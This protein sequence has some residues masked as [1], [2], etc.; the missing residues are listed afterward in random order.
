MKLWIAVVCMAVFTQFIAT[1]DA[2]ACDVP[3]AHMYLPHDQAID[4][5][6]WIVLAEAVQRSETNGR[7]SYQM[8]AIEH[9]K[10][11]G[12]ETFTIMN[13]NEL[14]RAFRHSEEPSSANYFAHQTSD[15]WDDAK[16]YSNWPDCR[17]HPV[18]GFSGPRYLIFGP[19]D[20][21]IGFENVTENDAWLNYVRQRVAGG[22]PTKPFPK[23]A[24]DYFNDAKAIVRVTA[25][26]KHNT[27]VWKETVIKGDK[28][29]YITTLF[30]SPAAEL[31]SYLN[32]ACANQPFL[33]HYKTFDF[34]YVLEDE[35]KIE[36]NIS[37]Y[38]WCLGD[39]H[40]Q[41]GYV[42]SYGLYPT[43]GFQR[44]EIQKERI[45]L[46]HTESFMYS[47]ERKETYFPK[48][49][50]EDEITLEQLKRLLNK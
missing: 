34:L 10:G 49:T 2:L 36:D 6:E 12:P 47:K 41:D 18:F 29:S 35:P 14:Q 50:I 3:P 15:F 21:A 13:R 38:L 11:S 27:A 33:P 30:I 37:R 26:W 1:Q 43:T 46:E 23:T 45:N 5:A 4:D 44:F 8:K 39:T 42:E 28:P 19:K 22:K 20:Y 17:I 24:K 16:T 7:P 48:A 40:E 9:V 25:E 31:S 32:P